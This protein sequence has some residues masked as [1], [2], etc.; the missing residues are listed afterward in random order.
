MYGDFQGFTCCPFCGCSKG[1]KAGCP[2][3]EEEHLTEKVGVCEICGNPIY[4]GDLVFK[5][6]GLQFHEGCF[7]DEYLEE[8]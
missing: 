8:A 2:N 1:H 5:Y 3:E 4:T 7:K 6:D